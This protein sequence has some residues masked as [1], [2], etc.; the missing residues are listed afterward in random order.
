VP[1][2]EA[3]FTSGTTQIV[4][5]AFVASDDTCPP[6]DVGWGAAGFVTDAD[7]FYTDIRRAKL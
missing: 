1:D 3:I 6:A 2:S 7:W 4:Q 5:P